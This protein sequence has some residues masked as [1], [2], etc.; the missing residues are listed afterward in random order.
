M[1]TSCLPVDDR[2]TTRVRLTLKDR[3]IRER[4]VAHP[5]GTGDRVLSDSDIVVAKYH[6]LTA[7]VIAA[8][9][10]AAIEKMVL[11]LDGLDHVQA[12][13]LETGAV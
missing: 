6:S 10:Q 3:S 4:V 2:L 13:R 7:L 9:R 8:D 12:D 1:R 11:A 5:R